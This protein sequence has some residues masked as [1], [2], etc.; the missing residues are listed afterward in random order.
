MSTQMPVK[1]NYRK[2]RYSVP[3]GTLYP[4]A[5][6]WRHR[7]RSPL[8]LGSDYFFSNRS[9]VE[10]KS[11]LSMYDSSSAISLRKTTNGVLSQFSANPP[12]ITFCC[13][14][15]FIAMAHHPAGN[16]V[17]LLGIDASDQGR[18]CEEHE[19]CGEVVHL[20]V[21]V[22][23]RRVQVVVNDVEE[24]AI[25]AYWVTDGIDR[26]RV[27]FLPKY[28]VKHWKQYDGKLAQVVEMYRDSESPSKRNKTH[29]RNGFVVS[30][31]LIVY[32]RPPPPSREQR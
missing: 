23:L 6:F 3:R 28:T 20:D 13:N 16:S 7:I 17:E 31:S 26:C 18:S 5:L 25:A 21:I 32:L 19:A 10:T 14:H 27:G 9:K 12:K 2:T 11:N 15:S 30:P 1:Y 29:R 22:R 4:F 8:L 24:T